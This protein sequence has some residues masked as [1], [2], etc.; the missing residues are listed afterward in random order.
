[1]NELKFYSTVC[2]KLKKHLFVRAVFLGGM[3]ALLL[4]MT[5]AFAP[6]AL[7]REYG[8]LIF[9]ASMLCIAL[10]LIPYKTLTSLESSPHTL[11]IRENVWI[12]INSKR[13]KK[14]FDVKT[15]KEVFSIKKRCR[16]G[17]VIRQRN[18]KSTYLPGL[19]SD[20]RLDEIMH[21]KKAHNF[22]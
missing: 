4:L 7:L 14:T 12:F 11:I 13:G 17:L 5:G 10:G 6:L 1:M 8:L 9:S 3:G 22:S 2:P 15:I 19:R 21:P 20:S 18:G 16:Y